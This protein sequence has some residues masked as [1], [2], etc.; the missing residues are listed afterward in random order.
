MRRKL[1]TFLL[2]IVATLWIC[3]LHTDAFAFDL[4]ANKHRCFSEE[5]PSSTE[6][7]ISYAALPGY[8]QFVDVVISGPQGN[9]FYTANAQD[10]GNFHEYISEGGD[11]TVCFHSRLAQ[12]AKFVEGMKRSISVDIKIG[13]EKNDYAELATKE[14]LRPIEV[15]LR[16]LEDAVHSIHLEYLYYKDKEAE[17]RNTN[18]VMTSKV[19]WFTGLLITV[20]VLFSAWELRHLKAYFKKKRLID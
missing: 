16:V 14:K 19:M 17:M 6:L 15:E 13:S 2:A 4:P 12:G 3:A 20:F 9:V 8:A 1:T 5:V 18:E 7:R 10:R 11:F